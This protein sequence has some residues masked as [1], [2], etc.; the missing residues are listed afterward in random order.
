MM[1]RDTTGRMF[2]LLYT[3][4]RHGRNIRVSNLYNVLYC[5]CLEGILG[6]P[7]YTMYMRGRDTR[8]SN[9][10]NVQYMLGRDTRLS[11]F[12]NVHAEEAD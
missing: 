1:G 5:T 4:Y 6:C 8:V 10:Y 7:T 3:T 12:Y 9:F 2:Y 11:Y